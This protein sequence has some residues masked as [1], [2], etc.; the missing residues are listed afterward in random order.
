M[1]LIPNGRKY[2][3]TWLLSSLSSYCSVPFTPVDFHYVRMQAQFFVQGA[4]T[5]SALSDINQKIC[6]EDNHKISIYIRPS[7]VPFSVQDKLKPEQIEQIKLTLYKRYDVSQQALDLRNL[8]FDPD[9]NAYNIDVDLNGR[10]FMSATLDIIAKNFPNT[11]SLNLSQN[12][13]YHLDSLSN[14]TRRAPNIKIL[15]LSKNEFQSHLPQLKSAWELDKIKGLNLEELWLEG[16]PLCNDFSDRSTYMRYYMLYDSEDRSCLLDIYHE[17]AYFS[18]SFPLKDEN[19]SLGNLGRYAKDSNMMKLLKDTVLLCQIMKHT[20]RDI[21]D[22]LTLLA[23]TKH[24]IASIL[25]DVCFQKENML[26]FS[27]NGRCKEGESFLTPSPE[28]AFSEL[29]RLP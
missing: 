16:N 23:R 29:S 18:L 27:V 6:S 15:N 13:L 19:P 11:L 8:R 3:R 2:G 22:C 14:L 9:L 21:V 10:N 5:A 12:K 17:K 20:R 4:S 28:G 26:Y 24:D 1:V 25:V 7:G